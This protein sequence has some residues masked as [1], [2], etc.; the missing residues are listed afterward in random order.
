MAN[1]YLHNVR[2]IYSFL[3]ICS[4]SSETHIKENICIC[5]RNPPPPFF[6]LETHSVDCGLD[7]PA[8]FCS[9]KV[10]VHPGSY[11]RALAD[12]LLNSGAAIL[13]G[14]CHTCPGGAPP[15]YCRLQMSAIN[16]LYFGGLTPYT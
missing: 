9:G 7:F 13:K 5:K 14:A 16:E 4:T 8:L 1:I 2:I 6:R 15:K 10:A 11:F 12:E 3:G